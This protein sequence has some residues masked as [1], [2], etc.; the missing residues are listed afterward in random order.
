[1]S[2]S[3][4][5]CLS[6]LAYAFVAKP[7][8]RLQRSAARH[9]YSM[10]INPLTQNVDHGT[11]VA[12]PGPR[13]FF[14]EPPRLSLS[15][16]RTLIFAESSEQALRPVATRQPTIASALMAPLRTG[17]Y[18]PVT[19]RGVQLMECMVLQSGQDVDACT[20]DAAYRH[21]ALRIAGTIN[22]GMQVKL[23]SAH[24]S[25]I[26]TFDSS[27]VILIT[28]DQ[29]L[30]TILSNYRL[31]SVLLTAETAIYI[32]VAAVDAVHEL[33][34]IVPASGRDSSRKNS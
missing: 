19:L 16:Y 9:E 1:M 6:I 31:Q 11:N 4:R 26:A 23:Q 22:R 30:H 27:P 5:E 2:W 29:H 24:D 25:T 15:S 12:P 3:R 20:F 18:D 34:I 13:V 33:R 7:S 28:T 10:G 21:P 14:D 17:S 8:F 32:L